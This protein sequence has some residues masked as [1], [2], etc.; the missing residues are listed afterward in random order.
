M[1]EVPDAA[2]RFLGDL[3]GIMSD[4][5][6]R[7]SKASESKYCASFFI[8]IKATGVTT[9]FRVSEPQKPIYLNVRVE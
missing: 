5:R 3:F 9:T 6:L 2:R 1:S 7:K 4:E 8:F